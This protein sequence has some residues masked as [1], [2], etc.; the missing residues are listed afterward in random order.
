M[1]F[2]QI[3]ASHLLPGQKLIKMSKINIFF[4]SIKSPGVMATKLWIRGGSRNDP[5]SQKGINQLLGSLLTRGCGPYDKNSLADLVEGCGA[6]LRSDTSEDGLLISLKCATKD[7]GKLL[8]ILGWMIKDPH[9]KSDQINL[10]KELALQVLR[11]QKENPFNI[12]YD[13][14]RNL[15]YKGSSYSHDPLGIENHIKKIGKDELLHIAEEIQSSKKVMVT[16]GIYPP[17]IK[18]NLKDLEPFNLFSE[19][20]SNND[21]NDIYNIINSQIDN[22]SN[23][24]CKE[25]ETE[26]VIL[27]LGIPVVPHGHPDDL[28][29]RL[30]S[31]HLGSGMS[32]LL[33]TQLREKYGVAY[34]VGV[35]HPT[36]EGPSPFLIHAS[37]TKEKAELT[38]KLLRDCWESISAKTL[39]EEQLRLAKAKFYGQ[40]AH[41][42]QTVGQRAERKAHLIGLGLDE[43]HDEESLQMLN[44]VTSDQLLTSARKHLKN[45]LLSLCGPEDSLIKLSKVWSN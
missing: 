36:R 37:T 20:E 14:W 4:D 29:I 27:M 15:A 23:L 41:S 8:P 32:S 7:A 28:P 43:K 24:V 38:L 44:K 34:D 17:S 45:P 19:K 5:S 30:L 2:N 35:H 22:N 10:E 12:A 16:A 1:K 21:N 13:E 18:S 6:A 33:F 11:R 39:S 26:Q 25:L 9:L 42:S 3:K 31:S 40:L